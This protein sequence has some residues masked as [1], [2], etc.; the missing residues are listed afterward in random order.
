MTTASRMNQHRRRR[1]QGL[2][3]RTKWP[4]T[5]RPYRKSRERPASPR[6]ERALRSRLPLP[7]DIGQ[8]ARAV[9]GC[10][11]GHTPV[12]PPRLRRPQK[13]SPSVFWPVYRSPR[14]LSTARTGSLPTMLQER[15]IAR[16]LTP[17]LRGPAPSTCAALVRAVVKISAAVPFLI[18]FSQG[19]GPFPRRDA[20]VVVGQV[21]APAHVGGGVRRAPASFFGR[22]R[23]RR[24]RAIGGVV[25][26]VPAPASP[27]SVPSGVNPQPSIGGNGGDDNIGLHVPA[28][29]PIES[30]RHG[31]GQPTR[32]H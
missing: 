24:V 26:Q 5:P 9:L 20:H 28:E 3:Y 14:R 29:Q 30:S 1:R 12:P 7:S 19:V 31:T 32:C 10:S 6:L 2:R 15:L 21:G 18:V 11:A 16:G 4:K 27:D 13:L 25:R 17:S 23:A 22:A 8:A